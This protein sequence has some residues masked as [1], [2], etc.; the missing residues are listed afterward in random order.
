MKINS[1]SLEE[2]FQILNSH[3]SFS[4]PEFGETAK[5]EEGIFARLAGAGSKPF[6]FAWSRSL[7]ALGLK[8]RGLRGGMDVGGGCEPA[9]GVT[10]EV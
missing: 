5:R 10:T 9:E 7:A 1:P 4:L 2:S 8:A 3:F 6:R